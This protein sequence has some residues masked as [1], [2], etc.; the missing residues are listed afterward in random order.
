MNITRKG[1]IRRFVKSFMKKTGCGY[2]EAKINADYYSE[3]DTNF[4]S[5]F[6][7]SDV[8]ECISDYFR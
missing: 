6:V 3:D 5:D 1:Y 4:H 2:E 8:N 7:E